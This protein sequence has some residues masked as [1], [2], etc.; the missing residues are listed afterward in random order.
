MSEDNSS[1]AD[2]QFKYIADSFEA[3]SA[4]R[5]GDA[6][7]VLD[8]GL[9]QHLTSSEPLDARALVQRMSTLI[10]YLE[11]RL[12]ED[13]GISKDKS[14][15]PE[16]LKPERRCSFCGNEQSETRKLIAGPEAI[17]C[18]ECI[19]QCGDALVDQ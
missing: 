6:L 5:Y 3:L 11:F 8:E 18:G 19:K 16:L 14:V 1:I 9:H 12:D 17:I 4:R 13:F 7:R 2:P 15:M 10:S